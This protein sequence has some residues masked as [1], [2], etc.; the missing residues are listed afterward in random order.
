M[1]ILKS[2]QIILEILFEHKIQ[3]AIILGLICLLNIFFCKVIR[4]DKNEYT[5]IFKC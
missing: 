5:K 2:V 1:A 4:S 3:I